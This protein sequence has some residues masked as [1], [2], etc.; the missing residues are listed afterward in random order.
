MGDHQ[1]GRALFLLDAPIMGK[2]GGQ[3][4]TEKF[5][6]NK[7][8]K[9]EI[10]P[11]KNGKPGKSALPGLCILDTILLLFLTVALTTLLAVTR[12]VPTRYLVV[13]GISGL[14][15]TGGIYILTRSHKST[16]RQV[17]GT[18]L[19]FAFFAV[20]MVG[21]CFIIRTLNTI[22]Q[23]ANGTTEKSNI[24]LYVLQDSPAE[25]LDDIAGD[26]IGILSELD[27]S[28]TDAALQQVQEE[29][30]LELTT[31]ECSG[32]Q[33]LADALLDGTV[34]GIVLNEAYLP[35]YEETD[36]YESFPSQLK[37]ISTHQV[38]HAVNVGPINDDHIIN[39]LISGSDTR[40]SVLDQ[41]GRSDVNIIASINTDT[42]QILLIS[43]PRDYFVPLD[44]GEADAY[45]KLTHAGIYGMDVLMGTLSNLYGIDL[46]Y[47]FRVNFT[48]FVGIIDA[49][50]GVDVYSE[51]DFS[52]GNYDYHQGMNTL[53]GEA[54]LVFARERHSFAQGDR[55]RGEN[56][57]AVIK[58]VLKKAMSP[59]ILTD[60]FSILK[61]VENCID[62]SLPYDVMADLVRRQLET[63][64]NWEIESY[65][66]NGS[67]A[68]ST[69]YSMN[70][71]L[72]V[73]IP[74]EATVQQAKEK[75]SALG[76]P[77][78]KMKADSEISDSE[79]AA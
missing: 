77:I 57:M 1:N 5:M 37:P 26:T 70:Q 49:L 52:A 4:S 39:L 25:T 33:A 28:N 16:K 34:D 65:S 22:Q 24:S 17:A 54:A 55:Q 59:N 43:T 12:V 62:T 19:A 46:D 31:V 78:K 7:Q 56:Q 48:G 58:A 23:V 64:A 69:T 13:V 44:V 35:I 67:D 66:V 21:C 36:G 75:L 61:S 63:G 71:E 40:D 20:A 15:L 50:G 79:P 27:R 38:E 72:Y 53:N 42:H 47:Y 18:V 3:T 9:I 11:M 6:K 32:L 2:A 30:G 74:D 73:M 8:E 45:D 14:I 41:R 68:R 60:Y 51:Y 76:N 10:Q 29:S